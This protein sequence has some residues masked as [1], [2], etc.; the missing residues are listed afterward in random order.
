MLRIEYCSSCTQTTQHS[1]LDFGH[2]IGGEALDGLKH[3]FDGFVLELGDTIKGIQHHVVH[4]GIAVVADVVDDLLRAAEERPP[5]H[6]SLGAII[7]F[8]W[9]THRDHQ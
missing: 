2:D 9:L 3:A 4:A 1:S 8:E 7:E 5:P 6:R